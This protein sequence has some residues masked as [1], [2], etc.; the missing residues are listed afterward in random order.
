MIKKQLIII[1]LIIASNTFFI[2]AQ[3]N[4]SVLKSIIKRSI[5]VSPRIKMLRA[6]RNIA[7]NKID[8]K[9]NL[10]DPMLSLALTNLPSSSF[11]FDADPMTRKV[12]GLT[13]KFPFPGKLSAL[14]DAIAI[15]T[16]IIDQEIND[17]INK[18]RESVTKSYYNLNYFRRAIFYANESKKLLKDIKDVVGVKYSVSTATQQNLVK[19]QLE[20]TKISDKIENLK[21][22]EKSA[23][24]KLN[25]YLLQDE[26]SDI[27]TELIDKVKPISINSNRLRE[28][29]KLNRPFLK[30]IR[31]SVEKAKLR[32]KVAR[33]DFYPNFSLGVQYSFRDQLS[34]TGKDLNNLITF[35]LGISLPLNYGGKVTAKVEEALSL[36][37]LYEE[38]YSTALQFLD[39]RFGSYLAEIESIKERINLFEEGL[40]PQAQQNF[41]SALASYQVNEV[42]FINV[43]DAQG[44]LFKIETNLYRLKTSYLKLIAD[45][46]FLI[47]T[48]L[49]ADRKI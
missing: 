4:N 39:G 30:G 25:A 18:I 23:L 47:G 8:Q 7:F 38:Q 9:S 49:S 24:S 48:S 28:L 1:V 16:L 2:S 26:N 21:S 46:E 6:K 43:I 40:L 20:I 22:R 44:Q 32:Q 5:E 13:Q 29:A 10:P 45:L 35:V 27:K 15:D 34:A 12:I 3:Q 42:D 11:T 17:E 31:L 33:K 14:E 19:V 41:K 37:K 36:Q